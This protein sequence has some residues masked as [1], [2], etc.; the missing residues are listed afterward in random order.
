MTKHYGRIVLVTFLSLFLG[1]GTV[2]SNKPPQCPDNLA[3]NCE[4]P[5][6]GSPNC[7]GYIRVIAT[8]PN[9]T[10]DPNCG[11]LRHGTVFENGPFDRTHVGNSY[12]DSQIQ[13]N[14]ICGRTYNCMIRVLAPGNA[15]D[16][17]FINGKQEPALN[18]RVCEPDLIGGPI[19]PFNGTAYD[20]STCR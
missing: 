12:G 7:G 4:C 13:G 5:A 9:D 10:I 6:P 16:V 3:Q 14:V 2:Y 18:F 19:Q 20:Q 8:H 11:P 15:L 17:A 1:V